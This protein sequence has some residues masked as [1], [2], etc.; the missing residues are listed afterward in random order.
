MNVI[1]LGVV[2]CGKVV[3]RIHLPALRRVHGA[4]VVALADPVAARR[5]EAERLA[6]GVAT[7]VDCEELLRRADI[8]AV[9]ICTPSA[10]HAQCALAALA[11]SKHV[12]VEKPLAS[13][14]RDAEAV[15]HAWEG[16]G[17]VGMSG[18]NYR[19][20]P[21]YVKTQEIVSSGILGQVMGIRSSF[22][23]AGEWIDE[24][25]KRRSS[26]GGVLL[27][28]AGHHI[29]LAEFIFRQRI[30]EVA[31]QVTSWGSDQDT[32]WT[33]M[34]LGNGVVMQSFFCLRGTDTNRFEIYGESAR[35]TVDYLA[36]T[37]EIVCR[38]R[39]K[40]IH[41]VSDALDQ[42]WSRLRHGLTQLDRSYEIA[43][44]KFVNAVANGCQRI[45]PDLHDALHVLQ[46]IDAAERSADT[47][48]RS[49]IQ[50][51]SE[52]AVAQW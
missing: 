13:N 47:G 1:R 35:L 38:G 42:G 12:Y 5:A 14:L 41:R 40:L 39:R 4:K 6:G 34:T 11:A 29:D 52:P 36:G 25:R 15:V 28:L 20:H 43:F 2:G 22:T 19:H 24:W 48:Q 31:A 37:L 3:C 45:A 9:M 51:I 27:D 49:R 21:L 7:F 44:S 32:A 50:T 16:T 46:V 23:S 8:D 26:G 10:Q 33:E 17:L 18:F 30:C